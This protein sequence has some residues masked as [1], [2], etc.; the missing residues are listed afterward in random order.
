MNLKYTLGAIVSFPL[1]PIMFFQG[2]K[3]RKSVPTLPEAEGTEGVAFNNSNKTI[4]LIT[5]G[6]STIAGVGVRTHEEG[7]TGTLAKVLGQKMGV[8]IAWRVYARSGYTAKRVVEKIVPK[9]TESQCDLLVVGLGGNDSFTLNTP[10]KWR[11]HIAQLIDSLQVKF[12][13]T[14]IV[15]TNMPP[16][17]AFPAFTSLIKFTIGNLGEI[18]GETLADL[19]ANKPNVYYISDIITVEKW[20]KKLDFKAEYKDFFSDGV[21]PSGLTYQ[22][23]AK[24][25]AGFIAEKKMIDL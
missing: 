5:I 7:F 21:H 20:I 25:V 10:T 4:K 11:L 6:E 8:N 14:P 9:I 24:E 12:P 23:W 3:I 1:L 19:V 16:I 17:K 18:L 22:T 15:F 13:N 2:K